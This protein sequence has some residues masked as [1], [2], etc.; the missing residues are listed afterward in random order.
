MS[1]M[2]RLIWFDKQMRALVYPNRG[3]LAEKFEISVRQAQRD[4]DYLKNSLEA[5]IKYSAKRR[6][7]YYEDESY[8]LPSVYI[9]DLQKRMLKFLAY[10]Y[11]NYTQTPKVAQLS[12]LFKKLAEED[13]IEDEIPIFDLGKPVVQHYYVIYN[14]IC[15][16]NKLKLTYRDPYKGN[17]AL[18]LDPYKLF[19]KYNADHL[20]GY[21]NELREFTVLRLDRIAALEVLSESFVVSS[22]FET[23][24]YSGFVKKEP[25]VAKVR[26]TCE[27][28]IKVDRG[29]RAKHLEGFTYEIEFFDVEELINLLI[30]NSRFDKVL[31]PKWL[32]QKIIERC[33]GIIGRLR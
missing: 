22:E 4:I 29:I 26:F 21:D 7:Y 14:A 23:K 18:K 10:R 20:A 17:V 9:N 32:S 15:S 2:H 11:G 28:N 13:E 1:N 16:K 12:E 5:P 25:Y 30:C 33:E 19:Y 24:K 31:F 27:Q 3:N 6:G 8:I